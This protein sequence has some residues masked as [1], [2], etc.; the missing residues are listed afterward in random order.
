MKYIRII[1]C[2]LCAVFGCSEAIAQVSVE[3]KIDSI[4]IVIGQQAHMTVEV[5]APKG[6]SI[7]WPHYKR[8][9][10]ITPGVEVL[11]TSSAETSAINSNQV[12][13]TK[14]FTLTSFDEKLYAIPG[15]K[16]KVNG[17]TYTGNQLAL[18]VVTMDVDTLHPNQFFPPKDV[19]NNPF[20]WS[21]WSPMF[22]LAILMLL[23]CGINYYLIIRLRENKPIIT[24]IR[25]IKK[26]LPHQKALNA[27]EKIKSEHLQRSEDQKIYYTELTETIRQYINERFGF[28]AMEMTSSEIIDRLQESGDQKMVDELRELFQTAD[29]VKFAK[30]ST[31]INEN[32]L[33]LVNAI[34]FIDQTKLEGQ[35][36]EERIVPKLSEQDKRS[37]QA[38]TT[39]KGAIYVIIVTVVALLVYVVFRTYQILM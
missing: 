7:Q 3:A 38:R 14:T 17:K 6:V 10:Y 12:K 13:V 28:N 32:D 30:Y 33:N 39:I 18:K 23:L 37:K 16:V 2:L 21:E 19:Q 9:Q 26:I 8:S 22:W 24:K 5:T 15:M 27:I 31:L 1:I 20:K 34:N 25:I 36:T 29:L 35:S 11:E 4:G